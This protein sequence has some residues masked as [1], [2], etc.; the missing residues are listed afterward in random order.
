MAKNVRQAKRAARQ[1]RRISQAETR[2]KRKQSVYEAKQ[3]KKEQKQLARQSVK[4]AKKLEKIYGKMSP[5][6]VNAINEITPLVGAMNKQL[7]DKGIIPNDETDPIE[8]SNLY[9]NQ[10]EDIPSIME[11]E[12]LSELYFERYVEFFETSYF[13]GNVFGDKLKQIAKGATTFI[14]GGLTAT[15][16]QAKDAQRTGQFRSLLSYFGL[17]D[18][19]RIGWATLIANLAIVTVWY[20]G[21]AEISPPRGTILMNFILSTAGVS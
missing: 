20:A 13:P 8:V 3:R 15:L 14:S 4:G 2:Q 18:A 9:A 1:Q 17:P 11:D 12:D 19:I 10:N 21:W 7:I 5:E 16:Q 6:E